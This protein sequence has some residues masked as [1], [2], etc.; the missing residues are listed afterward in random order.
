MICPKCKTPNRSNARYCDKCGFELPSV[1]PIAREIFGDEQNKNNN[2]Q[3]FVPKAAP[4]ADLRGVDK[5]NDSSYSPNTNSN[6][7]NESDITLVMPHE[8]GQSSNNEDNVLNYSN[9]TSSDIKI[10]KTKIKRN[11]FLALGVI[12]ILAICA[13][14]TYNMQ[15]WGGKIIPEVYGLTQ[16]EAVTKVKN[17]GFETEIEQVPSDEIEGIVVGVDPQEGSRADAG[18]TVKIKISKARI[19]PNVV[20][21]SLDEAKAKFEENGFTNIEAVT[22]KSD[23]SE[24]SVIKMSPEP[25]TRSK[26]DAKITITVADPYRVPATDNMTKDQAIQAIKD[27]GFDAEVVEQYNENL[28]EGNVISTNPAAGTALKS[29]SKVTIYVALHR[30][31]KLE[32]LT[33]DYFSNVSNFRMDGK[34]YQFGSLT[35]VQ[36]TSGGNVSFTFTARQYQSTTWFDG[37]VE[38]RYSDYQSIQGS[39][40][41]DDNNNV[42]AINPNI[43]T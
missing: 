35:A 39:I 20:G 25:N 42:I 22:E 12:A 4:T 40:S 1:A 6:K 33:R 7:T 41:F 36:W 18:S 13:L 26:A 29:K 16:S 14:V 31:T 19:I 15:L 27:S 2:D 8:G 32:Q 43:T 17:A 10:P 37:E 38:T 5:F 23:E 3:S 21:M 24:N 30:S 34:T 11:L 9:S 28:A